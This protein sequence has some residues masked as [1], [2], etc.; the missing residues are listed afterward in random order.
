MAE[1][2]VGCLQAGALVLLH[3][4]RCMSCWIKPIDRITRTIRISIDPTLTKRAKRI[5]YFEAHQ[6]WVEISVP[7]TQRIAAAKAVEPLTNVTKP[8]D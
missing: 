6:D 7:L 5:R 1:S 3:L 4:T 8:R 2:Y